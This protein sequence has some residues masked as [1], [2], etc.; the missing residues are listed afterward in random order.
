MAQKNRP[1]LNVRLNYCCIYFLKEI[2]LFP[3][4]RYLNRFGGYKKASNI[5]TRTVDIHIAKLRKKIEKDSQNPE[6]LITKRGQG[7]FLKDVKES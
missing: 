6:H 2:V 4:K 7:Y 3:E 5:E 1:T